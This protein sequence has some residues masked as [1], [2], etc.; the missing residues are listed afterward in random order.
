[1]A[2]KGGGVQKCPQN[3][4]HGLCMTPQ[5]KALLYFKLIGL[6]LEHY[7]DKVRL[8]TQ[9]QVS[10]GWGNRNDTLSPT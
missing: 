5:E 3:F 7:L 2:H 10:T 1:M 8:V 9:N 6:H 4:P